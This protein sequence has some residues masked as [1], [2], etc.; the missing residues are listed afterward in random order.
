MEDNLTNRL[1][2]V[3][4]DL[5]D[6]ENYPDFSDEEYESYL[7]NNEDEEEIVDISEE[8][9]LKMLDAQEN[10]FITCSRLFR[11]DFDSI[12][13]LNQDQVE[14]FKKQG[15]LIINDFI[16]HDLQIKA[17][18]QTRTLAS[19]NMMQAAGSSKSDSDDP[20]RNN[21]AR[22][23]LTTWLHH[24]EQDGAL[25]E[26]MQRHFSLLG[27]DLSTVIHLQ[28]DWKDAE[29]QLA[30]YKGSQDT[31][32]YYE[33]HRDA[34][35]DDGSDASSHMSQRRVTAIC[36]LN[37]NWSEKDGGQLRIWTNNGQQDIDPVGGRLLLFLSGAV[38][39]QVLSTNKERVALT[40]WF[41]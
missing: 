28:K 39:H 8:D 29:Y 20:Y 4:T 3:V 12:K 11:A 36:Y 10:P 31:P 24:N 37:H 14:L 13:L 25:G 23:D 35:P 2:Q 40:A 1:Q 41:S 6:E 33:K 30:Y 32:G 19:T 22:T 27:A 21:K 34:F 18:E 15:Y 5:G 26:L 17:F 9:M 38:D 7:N 16:P